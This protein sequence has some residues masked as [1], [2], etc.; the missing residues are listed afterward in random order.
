MLAKNLASTTLTTIL[1]NTKAF[2]KAQI[3]PWW[4]LTPF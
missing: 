3:I 2:K 4:K 1:R